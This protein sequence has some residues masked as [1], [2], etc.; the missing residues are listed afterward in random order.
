VHHTKNWLLLSTP[1]EHQDADLGRTLGVSSRIEGREE[2]RLEAGSRCV[3]FHAI[4]P[5]CQRAYPR[6]PF[7]CLGLLFTRR[8]TTTRKLREEHTNTNTTDTA[9]R[10]FNIKCVVT[11]RKYSK[12]EA[13]IN[14]IRCC[15][16][17][18]LY[19]CCAS[20]YV[21]VCAYDAFCC[22]RILRC[23]RAKFRCHVEHAH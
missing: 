1:A 22:T 6:R 3:G 23:A 8:H 12:M 20:P 13:R 4:G 18:R 7:L 2:A 15:H 21:R 11:S 10:P 17:T 16:N 9:L 5:T 19:C 14:R